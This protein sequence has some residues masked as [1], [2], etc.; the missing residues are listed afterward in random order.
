MMTTVELVS[1]AARGDEEIAVT[2][3]IRSGEH[4]QKETFVAPV[5]LVADLRLKTGACDTDCYDAVSRGAEVGS[6][7]K[8]GLY[9]LGYGSCSER[10]LVRKLVS[11]GFSKEIAEAAVAELDRRGYLNEDADALREAEK[12]IAKLWGQ[13][14]IAATL[15]TKGFEQE[16][17]QHALYTLEDQ[18]IDYAEL[19][20]ERIRRKDGEV[21]TEPDDRRRMMA[22][23]Q[24]NGFSISEIREAF[25]ML[26]ENA[27]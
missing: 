10:S 22:S 6:A 4:T 20:A 16:A 19:C 24:R 14:R 17:I 5:S 3:E 13:R 23:L 2:F 15:M 27:Q 11:K 8:R 12:C 18:G 7:V 21:P 26:E 1:L 9:I 25:R